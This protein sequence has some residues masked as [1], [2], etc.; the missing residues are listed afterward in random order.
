MT[1]AAKMVH[2]LGNA[3]RT[4]GNRPAVMLFH[5]SWMVGSVGFEPTSL[6]LKGRRSAS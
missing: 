2:D 4:A 3:P 6:D 1:F 5:Q